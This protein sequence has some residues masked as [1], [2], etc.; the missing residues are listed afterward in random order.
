MP[1]AESDDAQQLL[2]NGGGWDIDN[3]AFEYTISV[4]EDSTYY[5][6]A[7]FSTWHMNLDLI[8]T[9]TASPQEINIPVFWSHGHWM[10]TQPV[11]V[12][13]VKG[14]NVLKFSRY[15]D[16]GVAF[17][18]FFLFKVEPVVPTPDPHDLPVPTPPP[19]PLSDYIIQPNRSSCEK[20]GLLEL[21]AE[22]CEIACAYFG[23]KSTGARIRPNAWPGC[24]V[25]A[26]GEWAGN[27]NFNTNAAGDGS[28]LTQLAVCSR[29]A[30]MELI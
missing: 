18:E 12:P 21:T 24:F 1:N 4:E 3:H 26:T 13:M 30:V 23:Y 19:T 9:T 20:D 17:K 7:N 16:L 11:E 2:H 28:D 27:C 8:L 10:E 5:L 6:V 25:L 14:T 29:H 15:T 22:Q